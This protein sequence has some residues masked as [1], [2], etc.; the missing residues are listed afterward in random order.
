MQKWPRSLLFL[1]FAFAISVSLRLLETMQ[2]LWRSSRLENL[3]I[4]LRGHLRTRLFCVAAFLSLSVVSGTTQWRE[5]AVSFLSVVLPAIPS[6]RLSGPLSLL[7]TH[8]SRSANHISVIRITRFPVLQSFATSARRIW[9][10]HLTI[11]TAPNSSFFL[12]GSLDLLRS[13][14][15]LTHS[16]LGKFGTSCA[17][18]YLFTQPRRRLISWLFHAWKSR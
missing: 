16:W 7:L 18:L 15:P 3:G 10:L 2:R 8:L 17:R 12:H 14:S 11:S 13:L 4:A 5:F 9:H 1:S 6:I